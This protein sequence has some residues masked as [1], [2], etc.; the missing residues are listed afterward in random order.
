MFLSVE[1][2]RRLEMYRVYDSQCSEWTFAYVDNYNEVIDFANKY[3][4][5]AIMIKL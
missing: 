2:C 3:G 5:T 4:Y 1:Y